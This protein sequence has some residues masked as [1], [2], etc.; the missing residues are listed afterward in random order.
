MNRLGRLLIS[1]GLIMLPTRFHPFANPPSSPSLSD[2][3]PLGSPLHAGI[4]KIAHQIALTPTATLSEEVVPPMIVTGTIR[5]AK[6]DTPEKKPKA[7]PTDDILE[8]VSDNK[9]V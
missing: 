4:V 6:T 9:E 8:V 7:V 2:G 5:S 3:S 1:L